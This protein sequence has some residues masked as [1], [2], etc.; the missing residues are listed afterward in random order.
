MV[1][2]ERGKER[3]LVTKASEIDY[4]LG[5]GS[6]IEWIPEG[7]G[8][9]VLGEIDGSPYDYYIELHSSQPVAEATQEAR[10]RD[11]GIDFNLLKK[12]VGVR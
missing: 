6:D 7:K 1:K 4:I 3:R 11:E 10:K 9:R 5:E 2:K 12:I 8:F